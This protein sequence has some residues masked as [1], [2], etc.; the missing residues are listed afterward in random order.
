MRSLRVHQS[1]EK[2]LVYPPIGMVHG[3]P[4][5]SSGRFSQGVLGHHFG[6]DL[7][8]AVHWKKWVWR[9]EWVAAVEQHFI[10]LD[11]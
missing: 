6:F 3:T 7:S 1:L 11:V 2:V 10:F 5:W 8:L 4:T 9:E